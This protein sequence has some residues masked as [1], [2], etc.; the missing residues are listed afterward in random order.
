[1]TIFDGSVREFPL[2]KAVLLSGRAIY[3]LPTA[4]QVN[5][6]LELVAPDQRIASES[7]MIILHRNEA[8]GPPAPTPQLQV[9]HPSAI[10]VS[11]ITGN[12]NNASQPAPPA[13]V[14]PTRAFQP[15]ADAPRA[16]SRPDATIPP[17]ADI[18]PQPTPTLSLAISPPLP[19]PTPISKTSTGRTGAPPQSFLLGRWAYSQAYKSGSAFPT[20][21]ATL[22]MT[23]ADDRVHGVFVGRYR[24]P[25]NR[26]FSPLVNFN[27]EGVAQP[28]SS[29][30]RFTSTE[31]MEGE[32]ELLR[33][34]GKHNAI[35]VVWYFERDKLIFDDVFLRV[36]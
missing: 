6:Q 34:P 12:S 14:H 7:V 19:P 25:H 30:F 8:T 20:Q 13:L 15:P 11:A 29:K 28:G 21:S 31:G 10:R 4:D 24:V 22:A 1:L 26:K 27:F 33:L 36:P 3:G 18:N 5:V 23:E 17:V 35:E 32:I 9:Q 16:Q 2:D